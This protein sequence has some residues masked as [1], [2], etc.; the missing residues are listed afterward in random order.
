MIDPLLS[1]S[2]SLQSNKS[3]YALM[4][5]SGMSRSAQI[6]T[7]WEVLK[8]LTGQIAVL[9]NEKTD[10]DPIAWYAKK[11]GEAPDYSK[12]LEAVAKSPAERSNLLRKY[13]EPTDEE[14]ERGEKMPTSAHEAIAKLVAAGY[15]KVIVTTNFDRLMEM[16]LEKQGITPIIIASKDSIKGAPPLAHSE[17]T[18]IKL[19]G[20]YRDA[21]IRNT[22]DEL[23]TYDPATNKLLD[24]IFDE[25][26]LI[27][28][29]WSGDWDTA[30][31]AALQRC[32]TYRYTT[33]W[34]SRGELSEAAKELAKVRRAQII[35][36]PS[37]DSFFTELEQKLTALEEYDRPH[38]LSVKTAVAS[39]KK[40]LTDDKYRIQVHELLFE[41][42]ERAYKDLTTNFGT[43]PNDVQVSELRDR[44]KRYDAS[45]EMLQALIANLAYYDEGKHSREITRCLSRIASHQLP[46]GIVSLMEL[47]HYPATLLVYS[48]GIASVVSDRYEN[49]KATFDAKETDPTSDTPIQPIINNANCKPYQNNH[50]T[51]SIT[52]RQENEYTPLSEHLMVTLRP[53]L[54]EFIPDEAEYEKMFDKFEILL[55]MKMTDDILHRDGDHS[56]IWFPSGRFTWK[57][58]RH[59]GNT[60]L[61][62]FENEIKTEGQEWGPVNAGIFQSTEDAIAAL[63][64][65]TSRVKQLQW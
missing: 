52:G 35:T 50:F 44:L 23:S 16:A 10:N 8:D 4:L 29:G 46:N 21:R 60:I 22:V 58:R 43:N 40:G 39:L 63:G 31:R 57:A 36:I 54:R 20:D 14:R 61:V 12:V 34:T 55:A 45:A 9:E 25:Y 38:S 65:I 33:Y 15:I 59:Y 11:Y 7:G 62:D 24:Q 28:S 53:L 19:H 13:F 30:L 27:I 3:A 41:E 51:S 47:R 18:L 64:E 17:C 49:L 26:G 56:W 48:S 1:L 32:N 6:P 2:F 37:A 5:G 42:C